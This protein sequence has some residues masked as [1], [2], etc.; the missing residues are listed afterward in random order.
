MRNDLAG[1]YQEAG[2]LTDALPLFEATLAARERIL[3]PDHPDTL[4]SR[5]NLATAYQDA[6]RLTEA[7]LLY[8]TTTAASERILGPDHPTP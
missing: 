8:E 2:R 3:G 7:L 4:T 6:G 1:V 5:N